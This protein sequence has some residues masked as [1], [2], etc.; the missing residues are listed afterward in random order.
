MKAAA[1]HQPH[2]GQ[3]DGYGQNRHGHLPGKTLHG[4]GQGGSGGGGMLGV[5]YDHAEDDQTD[6][7]SVSGPLDNVAPE[8]SIDVLG[9]KACDRGAQETAAQAD[10]VA[11]D[12]VS[13]FG[14]EFVREGEDDE[15]LSLIH[16]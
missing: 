10:E 16:I 11:A 8:R 5:G 2:G 9:H 12:D 3:Q 4:N 14:G 6:R 1:K 13:R 7:H 15:G